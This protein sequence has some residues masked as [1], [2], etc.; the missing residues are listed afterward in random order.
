MAK[1][2]FTKESYQDHSWHDANHSCSG[3]KGQHAVT[4]DLGDHENGDEWP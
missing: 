2:I 4:D 3:G 1:G